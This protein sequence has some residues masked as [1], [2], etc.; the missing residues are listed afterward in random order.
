MV[1]S[2]DPNANLREPVRSW[3]VEEEEKLCKYYNKDI[4]RAAF[5][6]PNFAR[7]ALK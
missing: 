3:S 1:C 7:K 6:L 4:H 2:K 5:I